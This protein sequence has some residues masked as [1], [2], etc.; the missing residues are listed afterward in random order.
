MLNA[1]H[2][3]TRSLLDSHIGVLV[4]KEVFKP[5]DIIINEALNVF[6]TPVP[7]YQKNY[8]LP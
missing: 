6:Y 1:K 4:Y 2:A 7:N 5:S 8:L 3:G